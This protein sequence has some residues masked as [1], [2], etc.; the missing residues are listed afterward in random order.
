MR[1]WLFPRPLIHQQIR[2]WDPMSRRLDSI[3][4]SIILSWILRVFGAVLRTRDGVQ[5]LFVSPGHRVDVS[6]EVG[7]V[8]SCLGRYRIPEPI[9]CADML[10]K[11]IKREAFGAGLSC[12]SAQ[13]VR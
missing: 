1:F 3:T 5:S 2:R 13:H 6:T 10:S 12:D 7:I 8:L 9:R 11:K 4:A